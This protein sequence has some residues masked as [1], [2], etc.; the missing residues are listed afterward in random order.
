MTWFDIHRTNKTAN[1]VPQLVVRTTG[2]VATTPIT[3]NSKPTPQ[4]LPRMSS[5]NQTAKPT[6]QPAPWISVPPC[7]ANKPKPS[8]KGVGLAPPGGVNFVSGVQ[9]SNAIRATPVRGIAASSPIVKT[10]L[11]NPIGFGS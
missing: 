4:G 10:P 6:S 8:V 7:A 11:T 5:Q 1:R 9:K 3:A 2:T